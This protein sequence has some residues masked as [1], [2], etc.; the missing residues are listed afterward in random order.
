[1]RR[2]V[3]IPLVLLAACFASNDEHQ[4]LLSTDV[5][6]ATAGWSFGECG[7]HCNA[8]LEI[9]GSQLSLSITSNPPGAGDFTNHGVLHADA[10]AELVTIAHELADPNLLEVYGCPDCSDG[11][12]SYAVVEADGVLMPRTWEHGKPPAVLAAADQVVLGDLVRALTTCVG[13]AR[14]TPQACTPL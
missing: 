9:D 1:M 13:T 5:R 3:I 6:L 8:Q 7:I 10:Q 11:G 2:L 14:V 4:Q 12:A